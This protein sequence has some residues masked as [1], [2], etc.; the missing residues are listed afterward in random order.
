MRLILGRLIGWRDN[1]AAFG[2]RIGH[3]RTIPAKHTPMYTVSEF[4]CDSRSGGIP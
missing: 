3:M 4:R 1:Q 2:H